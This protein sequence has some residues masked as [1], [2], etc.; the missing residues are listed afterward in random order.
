MALLREASSRLDW[1]R[2]T[3]SNRAA[4]AELVE[5]TTTDGYRGTLLI[6]KRKRLK[7]RKFKYS[8]QLS[9]S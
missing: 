9:T 1:L 7:G 8:I 4:V 3:R 6:S 5:R 2:F